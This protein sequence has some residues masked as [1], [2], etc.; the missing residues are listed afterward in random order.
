[1][2]CSPLAPRTPSP[3]TVA[4][5]YES[6]VSEFALWYAYGVSPDGH[7]WYLDLGYNFRADFFIRGVTGWTAEIIYAPLV[8]PKDA[9]HVLRDLQTR[10]IAFIRHMEGIVD[11]KSK[12][13]VMAA[14]IAVS[15]V[16]EEV[17]I[18]FHRKNGRELFSYAVKFAFEDRG[19][20]LG[21]M[22]EHPLV[23]SNHPRVLLIEDTT[24]PS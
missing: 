6:W 18:V 4:V 8:D 22:Q 3:P 10:C 7:E 24:Y 16:T 12:M 14:C 23:E 9:Q 1:M 5:S 2:A 11:P 15:Q 20:L 17:C 19:F 21:L 13:H